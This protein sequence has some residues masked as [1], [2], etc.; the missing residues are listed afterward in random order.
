MK[1]TRKIR[2]CLR[3]GDPFLSEGPYN[4]RCHTCQQWIVNECASFNL[5][6]DFIYAI[7][8][9]EE[10]AVIQGKRKQAKAIAVRRCS[11]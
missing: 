9:D 2:N 5:E 1:P 4:R 3:C 10:V 7:S 6:Q 11:T 8:G